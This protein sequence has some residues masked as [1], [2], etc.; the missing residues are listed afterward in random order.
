MTALVDFLDDK[1]RRFLSVLATIFGCLFAAL[2]VFGVRAALEAGR[3]ASRRNGIETS[4]NAAERA[5]RTVVRDWERWTQGAA[6]VG[7][8]RG[9]WFFDRA[10]GVQAM[11]LDLQHVLEAADVPAPEIAFAEAEVIKDRLRKVTVGFRWSGSY[12]AF[13]RILETIEAHPRALYISKIDFENIGLG[14]GFLEARF[15][16]EGYY[17]QE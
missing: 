8:L 11:R 5:R 6:D 3:M 9:A 16:L 10:R 7:G 12:P 1:E 4:W 17:V 14:P 15:A 2:L 13:R